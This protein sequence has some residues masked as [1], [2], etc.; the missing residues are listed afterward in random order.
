M[1]I[2]PEKLRGIAEKVQPNKQMSPKNVKCPYHPRSWSVKNINVN[3]NVN[4]QLIVIK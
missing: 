4:D 1:K 2:S 3:N